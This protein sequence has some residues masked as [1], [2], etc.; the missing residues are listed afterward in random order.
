MLLYIP[1]HARATVENVRMGP[2][3]RLPPELRG[4]AHYVVP[5]GQGEVYTQLINGT[6]EQP[7]VFVLETP[8]GM[9]G[10]GPTRHQNQ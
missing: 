5:H 3:L 9:R 10:I 6:L 8:E 2:L 7:N 4:R 1:S